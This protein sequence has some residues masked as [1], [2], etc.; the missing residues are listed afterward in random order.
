MTARPDCSSGMACTAETG[1][2]VKQKAHESR[3]DC[4]RSAAAKFISRLARNNT[5]I[6]RYGSKSAKACSKNLWKVQKR[7][8][9][10]APMEVNANASSWKICIMTKRGE[11][12]S[13]RS[14]LRYTDTTDM[15]EEQK[16]RVDES[17][18]LKCDT[19]D[20]WVWSK[21]VSY[22]MKLW[23]ING[24]CSKKRRSCLHHGGIADMVFASDVQ[25][26][27]TL[28]ILLAIHAVAYTVACCDSSSYLPTGWSI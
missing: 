9:A 19:L 7:R 20:T 15:I 12:L 25:E 13:W 1:D 2:R 28:F 5:M 11:K 3:E 14:Q 27:S 21:F 10:S 17:E 24:S 16:P 23:Q 26:K 18:Q 4:E 6:S 22:M 8:Q